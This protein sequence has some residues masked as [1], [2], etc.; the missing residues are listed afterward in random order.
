M[1]SGAR[2]VMEHPNT[3]ELRRFVAG[4][5]TR[6][7]GRKIVT[8]LLTGCA[9]CQAAARSFAAPAALGEDSYSAVF[10]RL[11]TRA[12][13]SALDGR[14]SRKLDAQALFRE[15]EQLSRERQS[16]LLRNSNR[17]LS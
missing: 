14:K 7:E 2:V 13:F 11:E 6:Q 3:E 8:H 9:S 12:A 17:F 1:G 15:L 5:A 4:T 16:M 10:Q